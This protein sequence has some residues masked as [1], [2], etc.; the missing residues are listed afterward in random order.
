MLQN[1]QTFL[2]GKLDSLQVLGLCEP[3]AFTEY[4][5]LSGRGEGE[6]EGERRRG[7]F[8]VP[9]LPKIP[10]YSGKGV[11]IE[12]HGILD[13]THSQGQICMM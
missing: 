10:F 13:T 7:S 5:D 1:R 4:A 3:C 2:L 9:N 6:G 12:Y 8:L 11:V